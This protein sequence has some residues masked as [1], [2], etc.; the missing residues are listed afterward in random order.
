MVILV[1]CFAVAIVLPVVY[2]AI[3]QLRLRQAHL[4]YGTVLLSQP[5]FL[6]IL[7]ICACIAALIAFPIIWFLRL[8]LPLF[9]WIIDGV[10]LAASFFLSSRA[11]EVDL[12]FHDVYVVFSIRHLILWVWTTLTTPIVANHPIP[13]TGRWLVHMSALRSVGPLGHHLGQEHHQCDEQ[14]QTKTTTK[15]YYSC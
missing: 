12:Y 10:L 15:E 1:I 14:K 6:G 9:C 4:S 7:V 5:A 3:I 2:A 8:R 11:I 13:V